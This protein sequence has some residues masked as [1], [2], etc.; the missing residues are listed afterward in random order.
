MGWMGAG[1][2]F[3]LGAVV[4]LLSPQHVSA[5]ATPQSPTT[6]PTPPTLGTIQIT[7]QIECVRIGPYR[8]CEFIVPGGA[9]V[10]VQIPL[11]VYDAIKS[12][13]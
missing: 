4:A 6:S 12:V 5:Q 9:R 13:K 7:P 2:G 8:N 1:A 10:T 3:A 11:E